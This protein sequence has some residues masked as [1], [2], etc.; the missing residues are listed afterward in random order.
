LQ[1]EA[2]DVVVDQLGSGGVVADNDKAGRDGDLFLGPE[3][4]CLLVVAIERLKRG[5]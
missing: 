5:L 1:L 3:F 2:R 4:E